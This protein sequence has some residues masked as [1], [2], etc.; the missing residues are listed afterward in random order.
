MGFRLSW[1]AV[2][3]K[4][5][6]EIHQ[7]LAISATGVYEEFPESPCTGAVLADG[8]YLVVKDCG[9]YED[10]KQLSKLSV[11][12]EV[13]ACFV[14]EGIMVSQAAEWRNGKKIW[15]VVHNS[16]KALGHLEAQGKL[17]P[18]YPAL[19]EQLE[20]KQAA[21]VGG[22]DYIFDIPVE[23]AKSLTGYRH[24][25]DVITADEKGFEVLEIAE[26][27]PKQSWFQR[28]FG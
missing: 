6:E 25:A 22:P 11:K 8:S 4:T 13:I 1:V 18:D 3:G 24:D 20:A 12:G 15:S 27:P 14:H 17:P 7:A 10:H 21:R 5:R 2:R 28:V 19:R 16:Q 26:P 9:L 23:L